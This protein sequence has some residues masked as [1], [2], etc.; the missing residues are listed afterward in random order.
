MRNP[1]LR[2]AL[3]F[4]ALL[5]IAMQARAQDRPVA[6]ADTVTVVELRLLDGSR[7]VGTIESESASEIVLRTPGGAVIRIPVDQVESRRVV[8]D[9]M[10]DG[11]YQAAD[12]NGSRLF[13]TSTGRPIGR[14]RG[15][16]ADYY[17]LFPF[18]AFGVGD[19]ASLGAGVSL[20]PGSSEQLLYVAPKVTLVNSGT[21]AI[22][23]GALAGTVTSS[24]DWAGI[25][26]GVGTF[27]SV[28]RAVTLGVGFAWGGGEV[29]DTPVFVV[30]GELRVGPWIKLVT[31][32]YVV[33][34]EEDAVL[35]SAGLRFF[36][37]RVAADL[38][39]ITIPAAFEEE[40]FPFVP[41]VG[42]AYN[43]GN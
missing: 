16:F 21:T 1:A 30:G 18:V 40:G 23:A 33:P 32:N 25:L 20:I 4:A 8:T 13:F 41:F 22:A 6:A 26:Y 15:Y 17:V 36:G 5:P 28:D 2:I 39:L 27:G 43:F 38:A 11:R 14:G 19:A 31:E 12:P 34:A 37:E 24:D 29:S 3:L 42:F 10:R 35:F 7:L 9:R